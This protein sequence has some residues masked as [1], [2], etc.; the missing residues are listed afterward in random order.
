MKKVLLL[1]A[2]LICAFVSYSQTKD[3][4]QSD[5]SKSTLP[6]IHEKG[7]C[8]TPN[9]PSLSIDVQKK[10]IERYSSVKQANTKVKY[11]KV[12]IPIK[13]HVIQDNFGFSS[14]ETNLLPNLTTTLNGYFEKSNIEFYQYGETEFIK[15]SKLYYFNRQLEADLRSKHGTDNVINLYFCEMGGSAYSSFPFNAPGLFKEKQDVIMSTNSFIKMPQILA[16]EI[17][18]FF[19]LFHT[20]EK[21]VGTENVRRDNCSVA[22]DLL[23]DTAADPFPNANPFIRNCEYTGQLKDQHGDLYTPPLE[24][25]M[26]Y[27]GDCMNIFTFDQNL[28]MRYFLENHPNRIHFIRTPETPKS[29]RV[30][31]H[32]SEV[33]LEWEYNKEHKSYFE[34]V[35]KSNSDTKTFTVENTNTFLDNTVT[36]GTKYTYTLK[37]VNNDKSSSTISVNTIVTG[38]SFCSRITPYNNKIAYHEGD[39]VLFNGKVYT[40]NWWV[41]GIDP[42]KGNHWK[43][44][45]SCSTTNNA[46]EVI[47][48][49][50]END[51]SL[52]VGTHLL[53]ATASDSDGKVISV[54]FTVGK[55]IYK[56]KLIDNKWQAEVSLPLADSLAIAAIA[57]DNSGLISKRTHKVKTN[58]NKAPLVLL[59][60]PPNNSTYKTG[61][62]IK[63]HAL[64]I[65]SDKN[66]DQ[67]YFIIND[68]LKV[69]GI[70]DGI[71]LRADYT[72]PANKEAKYRITA[73]AIDKDKA[74]RTVSSN[75]STRN[76]IILDTPKKGSIYEQDTLSPID[77]SVK[78]THPTENIRKVV[79]T[80]NGKD[81]ETAEHPYNIAWTPSSYGSYNIHVK[82][83]LT[84]GEVRQQ[85]F[86]D[87]Q[88]NLVYEQHLFSITKPNTATK[89]NIKIITPDKKT[90]YKQ[91]ETVLLGAY[92]DDFNVGINEYKLT[93]YRNKKDTINLNARYWSFRK[94]LYSIERSLPPGEYE[95]VASL[96]NKN[97]ETVIDRKNFK[98]LTKTPIPMEVDDTKEVFYNTEDIIFTYRAK[99]PQKLV[100]SSVYYKYLGPEGRLYDEEHKQAEKGNEFTFDYQPNYY[101]THNILFTVSD[102]NGNFGQ[103]LRTIE[104]LYSEACEIEAFNP[105][106]T[107]TKGNMV[108]VASNIY[109]AKYW[110]RGNSPTEKDKW[111][112]WELLGHCGQVDLSTIPDTDSNIVAY[113]LPYVEDGINVKLL[114][115]TP[116]ATYTIRGLYNSNVYQKGEIQNQERIETSKLSKN[117]MYILEIDY[118]NIKTTKKFLK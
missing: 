20:F 30:I 48:L 33:T 80:I 90:S 78:N 60:S 46:P 36:E 110:V 94:F 79:Y 83:H 105:D 88:G 61:A 104:V 108:K 23:C 6:D 117:T 39:T 38:N 100:N 87:F 81:Y 69:N 49:S 65:D 32:Y 111:G 18:H 86:L 92:I 7:F 45:L 17:G 97:N 12:Y 44:T 40:A 25:L 34:I 106:K 116:K 50:P 62:A 47:S 56:G 21:A 67:A 57:T 91:G 10:A 85:L 59:V 16:H 98:V 1:L 103:E 109:K 66:L 28:T 42:T 70:L 107:Y 118:N 63:L 96:T 2:Y 75:I 113:P 72:L 73:Y 114:G 55:N 13:I 29:F 41:Q 74:F 43:Y 9:F 71:H 76:E 102:E 31:N 19:G 95:L 68:S 77:L 64:V 84:N 26:S 8:S 11:Q 58:N 24:N 27:Y 53:T 112:P 5:I 99:N 51:S 3:Y 54:N 93:L 82:A 37:A 89:P 14:L 115:T 101:G 15:N 35:R 4:K 52:S 22:G